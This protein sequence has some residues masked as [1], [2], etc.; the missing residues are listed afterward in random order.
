MLTD[1]EYKQIRSVMGGYR[2]FFD[3]CSSEFNRTEIEPYKLDKI[4]WLIYKD[5]LEKFIKNYTENLEDY[6]FYHKKSIMEQELLNTLRG[7]YWNY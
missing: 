6:T 1:Q 7:V 5:L 4:A 3:S 2:C